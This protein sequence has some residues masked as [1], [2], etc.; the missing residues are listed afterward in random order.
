MP[1]CPATRRIGDES[2]RLASDEHLCRVLR[3]IG[4]PA[5]LHAAKRIEELVGSPTMSAKEF[6][7][8]TCRFFRD[9]VCYVDPPR[10][11]AVDDDG[12]VLQ[13]RPVVEPEDLAC[14]NWDKRR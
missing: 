14:M 3:A 6:C 12:D 4:T 1:A 5:P 2:M 8:G 13:A 9:G 11:I 10:P 7:C